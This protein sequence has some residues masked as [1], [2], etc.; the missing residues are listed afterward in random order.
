VTTDAKEDVTAGTELENPHRLLTGRF[1]VA[2]VL[3]CLYPLLILA[4]TGEG[5]GPPQAPPIRDRLMSTSR[6]LRDRGPT[7]A[8]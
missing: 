7:S 4:F 1:D 6:S 5:A 2:F 8:C 3:I